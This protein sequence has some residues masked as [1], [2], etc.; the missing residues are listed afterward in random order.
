MVVELEKAGF[1]TVHVANMTPVSTSL[2]CNRIVKSYGIP[3]PYCDPAEPEEVQAQQRYNMLL[4]AFDALGTDVTG[5]TV[6]DN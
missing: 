1:P 4:R 3:Y 5:P 6:F 2:G